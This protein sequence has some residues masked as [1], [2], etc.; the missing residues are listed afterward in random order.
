M[1]LRGLVSGGASC[2]G[3]GASSTSSGRNPLANLFNA[4]LQTSHQR[5]ALGE[6]QDLAPVTVADRF[7]DGDKVKIRTRAGVLVGQMFPGQRGD[8]ID[9]QLRTFLA[10]LHIDP[11]GVAEATSTLYKDEHR[12]HAFMEAGGFG[13]AHMAPVPFAHAASFEAAAPSGSWADEFAAASLSQAPPPP[14][15]D[16]WAHEFASATAP[17]APGHRVPSGWIQGGGA[18]H[19]GGQLFSPALQLGQA[20][21]PHLHTGANGRVM[22]D[23]YQPGVDEQMA[24]LWLEQGLPVGPDPSLDLQRRAGPGASRDVQAGVHP[25]A[26]WVD[27]FAAGN[28]TQAAGSALLDGARHLQ[29]G[30]SGAA[31]DAGGDWAGEYL[32]GTV[33]AASGAGVRMM[34]GQGVA[35]GGEG[36]VDWAAEYAGGQLAG[37]PGEKVDGVMAASDW[38]EEFEG[39]AGGGKTRTRGPHPDDPLEDKTALSW[40]DQFNREIHGQVTNPRVKDPTLAYEFSTDNPY[41]SHSSPYIAG[42]SLLSEGKAA[43]AVLAFEAAVQKGRPRPQDWTMLGLAL[44][45]GEDRAKAVIP[46][47]TALLLDPNHRDALVALAVHS[48][49]EMRTQQA[50]E[51]MQRWAATFPPTMVETGPLL[52]RGPDGSLTL[53]S[54]LQQR[55]EGITRTHAQNPDG[56]TMQGLF[57]LLQDRPE[58]ALASFRSAVHLQPDD[59]RLLNK[60]AAVLGMLGK[61]AE[62]V[63]VYAQAI[64]VCPGYVKAWSNLG[65]SLNSA[66]GSIWD[67]LHLTFTIM[68]RLDLAMLTSQRQVDLF[69]KDFKF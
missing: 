55:I 42:V 52:S 48:A 35:L 4:M 1:S 7:S 25:A 33:S 19:P 16:Q 56:F 31:A 68:G 60:L 12:L 66:S 47:K 69:R 29:D 28:G 53:A 40:V 59:P 65:V 27:E 44:M 61:H 49:N 34:H 63:D 46:L 3:E 32:R 22:A 45:D 37:E 13:G 50:M 36:A 15:A 67:A 41:L 51:Y 39:S 18:P 8:F 26:S 30:A 9:N 21:P 23:G 38:V 58:A 2:M 62:A 24:R 5:Q 10:R 20:P 64:K 14:P 57:H 6:L 17:G 54:D 43:E 11:A